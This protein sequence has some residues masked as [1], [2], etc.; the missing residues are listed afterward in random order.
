MRLFEITFVGTIVVCLF[1]GLPLFEA[2]VLGF[3]VWSLVCHLV[4]E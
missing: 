4:E 2:I 1:L 3:I